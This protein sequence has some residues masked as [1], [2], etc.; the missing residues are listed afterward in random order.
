MTDPGIYLPPGKTQELVDYANA[1]R[2]DG[3][4]GPKIYDALW[5]LLE[6]AG[7]YKCPRCEGWKLVE[8]Y[9]GLGQGPSL[10]GCPACF[11]MGWVRTPVIHTSTTMDHGH[12]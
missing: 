5:V 4:E 10:T 2:G 8:I 9:S 1:M 3:P 12:E 11:E 6:K 7:I